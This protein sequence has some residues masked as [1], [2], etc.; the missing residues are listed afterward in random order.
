MPNIW[1]ANADKVMLAR[2]KNLLAKAAQEAWPKTLEEPEVQTILSAVATTLDTAGNQMDHSL[3]NVTETDIQLLWLMGACREPQTGAP[4]VGPDGRL[5]CAWSFGRRQQPPAKKVGGIF[6]EET[7][8]AAPP[9]HAG[10]RSESGPSASLRSRLS[11]LAEKYRSRNLDKHLSSMR[12][13]SE[14]DGDALDSAHRRLQSTHAA[15][16][17]AEQTAAAHKDYH[18]ALLRQSS[19]KPEDMSSVEKAKYRAHPY[20]ENAQEKKAAQQGRISAE[21][22]R[23]SNEM[24][25]HQE[26]E[27]NNFLQQLSK[28]ES[29]RILKAVRVAY[30]KARADYEMYIK[31]LP[32][33][34]NP[35]VSSALEQ[36]KNTEKELLNAPDRHSHSAAVKKAQE[37]ATEGA[38][39]SYSEQAKVYWKN[40]GGQNRRPGLGMEYP[41]MKSGR[42][43]GRAGSRQVPS[44]HD[45]DEFHDAIEG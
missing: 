18:E 7:T 32:T 4:L 43:S 12:K 13:D 17:Q 19:M 29:E 34:L 25:R 30:E 37:E 42:K 3:E 14:K 22:S 40:H 2:A 27:V 16:L 39:R 10:K 11:D 44:S 35:M 41:Q 6:P 36:A 33:F 15:K 21:M 31:Q 38:Q 8:A 1:I 20:L 28:S 23:H 5:A 45:E 26:T 9:A 24:K